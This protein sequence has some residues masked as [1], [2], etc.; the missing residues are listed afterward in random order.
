MVAEFADPCCR[1]VY[2]SFQRVVR[3]QAASALAVES[4]ASFYPRKSSSPVRAAGTAG[5]ERRAEADESLK[6]LGI[7]QVVSHAC[8]L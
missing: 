6:D 4:G 3:R 8:F 2:I 1:N 7:S 5:Q